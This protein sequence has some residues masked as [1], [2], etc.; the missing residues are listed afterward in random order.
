MPVPENNNRQ[1]E[2]EVARCSIKKVEPQPPTFWQKTGQNCKSFLNWLL[3][4]AFVAVLII[5][6]AIAVS[7]TTDDMSTPSP[8]PPKPI[9]EDL[10]VHHASRIRP[11]GVKGALKVYAQNMPDLAAAVVDIM[12]SIDKLQP[13]EDTA[14]YTIR[15]TNSNVHS[16]EISQQFITLAIKKYTVTID[17]EDLVA[18][19]Y[20]LATG[21]RVR[22]VVGR[23][24]LAITGGDRSAVA[25]MMQALVQ[26]ARASRFWPFSSSTASD[27]D[28]LAID[29]QSAYNK[30]GD[31]TQINEQQTSAAKND[32]DVMHD[33]SESDDSLTHDVIEELANGGF[34]TVD[35]RNQSITILN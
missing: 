35:P 13:A 21:K 20:V 3:S 7:L 30:L 18:C 22:K 34:V 29:D 33:Y 17:S 6:L 28:D 2:D 12:A 24:V 27:G 1:I 16:N 11:E 14:T 23:Q 32:N 15:Q 9:L 5:A 8:L 10:S 26:A 25:A 19:D 4:V 31:T